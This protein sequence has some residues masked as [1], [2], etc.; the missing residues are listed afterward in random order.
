MGVIEN[1]CGIT[2]FDSC[3]HR[4]DLRQHKFVFSNLCHQDASKSMLIP[5]GSRQ[6]LLSCLSKLFRLSALF[7]LWLLLVF[8]VLSP[9]LTLRPLYNYCYHYHYYYITEHTQRIWD[10]FPTSRSLI[11]SA[12]SFLCKIS[13]GHHVFGKPLP[14]TPKGIRKE[15][16]KTMELLAHEGKAW[17]N[18]GSRALPRP[19]CLGLFSR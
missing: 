17:V 9:S 10:G 7:G 5:T 14:T 15:T 11:V 13:E 18:R 8:P 2:V 1:N 12:V 6:D 19:R 16:V 3:C 4:H